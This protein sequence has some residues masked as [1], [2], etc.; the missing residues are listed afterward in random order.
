MP[1]SFIP[2]TDDTEYAE[3]VSRTYYQDQVRGS[4]SVFDSQFEFKLAAAHAKD[5]ARHKLIKAV[6][7]KAIEVRQSQGRLEEL[8][9]F[10]TGDRMVQ[11]RE[12]DGLLGAPDDAIKL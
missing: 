10:F 11:D 8:G 1:T 2:G 9:G 7:D 3:G 5:R 12:I 4:H 6:R